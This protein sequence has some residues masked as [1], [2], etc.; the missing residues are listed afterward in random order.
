M[1]FM[2]AAVIRL[3]DANRQALTQMYKNR[4]LRTISCVAVALLFG[5]SFSIRIDLAMKNLFV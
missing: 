5:E 3:T 4:D 2:F 1:S